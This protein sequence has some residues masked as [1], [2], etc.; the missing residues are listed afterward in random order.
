MAHGIA[1]SLPLIHETHGL[2]HGEKV[3][4]GLMTQLCLEQD[5]AAKEI[6]RIVDFLVEVGLRVTF[7][8]MNMQNVSKER[9]LEFAQQ[10]SGAESFVH[11]HPFAVTPGD[12]VDAMIAAD[13]L[14]RRRNTLRN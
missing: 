11:N 9:L 5:L 8:D 10:I 7:E 14:G 4:F 12:I 13:S 1:N 3:S 2:L 6:Y